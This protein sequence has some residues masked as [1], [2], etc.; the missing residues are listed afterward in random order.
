[1]RNEILLRFSAPHKETGTDRKYVIG[2]IVI[3]GMDFDANGQ[4]FPT[5]SRTL[6]AE[7]FGWDAARSAASQYEEFAQRIKIGAKEAVDSAR[8]K[9]TKSGF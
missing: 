5:S 2:R 6:H 9:V 8:T 3:R 4:A 7:R 1:M